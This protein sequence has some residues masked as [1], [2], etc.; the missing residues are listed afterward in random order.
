MPKSPDAPECFEVARRWIDECCSSH[1]SCERQRVF[2]LPKRV[3][4]VGPPDGS[5]DPFLW[6]TGGEEGVWIALSY[7]WG[8]RRKNNVLTTVSSL[9]DRMNGMPFHDLP[10]TFRDAVAVTR[11]LGVQYLWIDSICIIQDSDEDKAEQLAQMADIY[12]HSLC[13][14]AASWA[15]D[16]ESGILHPRTF[17]PYGMSR[18]PF[19]KPVKTSYIIPSTGD[20]GDLWLRPALQPYKF[21]MQKFGSLAREGW[22]RLQHRG[23]V[24][25]ETVLSPRTLHYTREQTFWQCRACAFG[26]GDADIVEFNYWPW[27][28]W[29]NDKTLLSASTPD[30]AAMLSRSPDGWIPDEVYYSMHSN[31][32][33]LV[34]E[35]AGRVLSEPSDMLPAISAA[36]REFIRLTSDQY[37][38]GIWE[39][40]LARG[41]LWD[42]EDTVAAAGFRA[43]SWSWASRN[44]QVE[45]DANARWL[46][47]VT[48]RPVFPTKQAWTPYRM[49]HDS[50]II[51]LPEEKRVRL[52]GHAASDRSFDMYG[53]IVAQSITISAM[54][55]VRKAKPGVGHV[56]LDKPASAARE[57]TNRDMGVGTD[58]TDDE[59][60]PP[61]E[62]ASEPSDGPVGDE[63]DLTFVM[64][65]HLK[66]YQADY[67]WAIVPR[68]D[69]RPQYWCLILRCGPFGPG[70]R[71]AFKRVGRTSFFEESGLQNA[72]WVRKELTIY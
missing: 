4:D 66:D 5:R 6:E 23:W 36:A 43:P 10:A 17:L 64:M 49:I 46:A 54:C 68:K 29:Q 38:A 39:G 22:N 71:L 40:D 26:E 58:D 45:E 13:T 61:S 2:P 63:E 59:E 28:E 18:A 48:S 12:R 30:R 8:D 56:H 14:V 27:Y 31:W 11:G 19:L 52:L 44:V 69:P 42:S 7:Q 47:R 21:I 67:R 35:Y 9:E 41:L 34:N 24:L 70:G 25:Q 20:K 32:L 62:T 33:R 15:D 65:A 51:H 72:D 57:G 50:L 3:I 55:L 16:C 60:S 1:A 53:S 37:V